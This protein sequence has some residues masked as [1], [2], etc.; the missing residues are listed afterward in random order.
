MYRCLCGAVFERPRILRGTERCGDGF[1][2]R[3][4][5]LLCPFCGL[6]EQYF[7]ELAEEDDPI[8]ESILRGGRSTHN[9][10]TEKGI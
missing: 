9:T 4:K 8:P 2:R 6:G 5:Y 10:R 1:S 3:V 7:E